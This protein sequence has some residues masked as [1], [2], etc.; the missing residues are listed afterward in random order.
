MHKV[1]RLIVDKFKKEN[2]NRVVVGHN[3]NMKQDI[4][5]GKV[6]NQNIT[7]FPHAK[8]IEMLKYKCALEGIS[9]HE[10]NE[11]YT[12]KCSF[13]DL[14][15]IREHHEYLGKRVKRGKFKSSSGKYIDADI[16]GSY[17]IMRKFEPNIINPSNICLYETKPK[18]CTVF[19]K[20]KVFCKRK[21][22]DRHLGNIMMNNISHKISI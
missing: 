3:D 2:V 16:N 7:L 4:D 19:Q 15:D 13:L 12:S 21:G 14:E 9:L 1:T 8:F 11:S 22:G 17:N 18:R 20:T 6:N 5:L 10:I